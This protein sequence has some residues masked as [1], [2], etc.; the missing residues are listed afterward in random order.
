MLSLLLGL[1]SLLLGSYPVEYNLQQKLYTNYTNSVPC[2]NCPIDIKLGM[3]LRSIL[4][5]SEISGTIDLNIWLRHW[6]K[7]ERLSWD[8]NDYNIT[9]TTL[10]SNSEFDTSM[11]TPDIKLINTAEK[12][13]D[14]LDLTD[15]IV[16]NTGDVIWSRPGIIKATCEYDLYNFPYDKQECNFTFSSWSYNGFILNLSHKNF[17]SCFDLSEMTLHKSWNVENS[18]CFTNSKIYNCCPEPYPYVTF[19][20]DIKRNSHFFESMLITP[21]MLTGFF[22]VVSYFIPFDSGERISF[23]TT[24]FLAITVF[25]VYVYEII[26]DSR[27]NPL[28]ADILLSFVMFSFSNVTATLFITK[29]YM[30]DESK[31]KRTKSYIQSL[32][33]KLKIPFSI[34]VICAIISLIIFIIFTVLLNSI[35][36]F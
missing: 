32:N 22:Y 20:L 36:G 11:W 1:G 33:K 6:W 4:D 10:F 28:F 14:N 34:N 27:E 25:L 3:S 21:L 12:P 5:V 24:V 29:Y 30:V 23:V 18:Q 35:K 9:S 7:D 17:A 8:L 31:I 16:Y 19:K 13:L 2:V 26:P 15:V